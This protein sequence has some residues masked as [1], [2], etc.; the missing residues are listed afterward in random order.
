MAYREEGGRG[1]VEE[2]K[3]EEK[4]EKSTLGVKHRILMTRPPPSAN[5]RPWKIFNFSSLAT[6]C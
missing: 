4:E 2:E 3:E 6:Q 5:D 1:E